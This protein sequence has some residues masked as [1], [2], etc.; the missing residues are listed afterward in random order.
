MRKSGGAVIVDTNVLLSATAP[1]H[2]LHHAAQALFTA[3]G[4]EL[5]T[6]GQILREYLVIAARPQAQNGLGLAPT[7]ALDNAATFARRMRF[8][9]EKRLVQRRLEALLRE[10]PCLGAQIHDANIAATALAHGV[11]AIITENVEDFRRWERFLAVL[12]LAG[13]ASPAPS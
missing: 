4:R 11:E 3:P 9:D 1:S 8:L 7:D 2:P 6:S 5:C 10:A 12:H 13:E